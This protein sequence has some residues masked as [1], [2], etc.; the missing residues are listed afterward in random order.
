M[1]EMASSLSHPAP[2]SSA[3]DLDTETSFLYLP[4]SI[5]AGQDPGAFD[6]IEILAVKPEKH[7]APQLCIGPGAVGGNTGTDQHPGCRKHATCHGQTLVRPKV[8]KL[9]GEKPFYGWSSIFHCSFI[10]ERSS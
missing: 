10:S 8:Q 7:Q 9:A 1:R 4:I 6:L 3:R 5:Q 2:E